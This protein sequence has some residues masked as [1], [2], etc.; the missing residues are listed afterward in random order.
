MIFYHAVSTVLVLYLIEFSIIPIHIIRF[1]LH[2]SMSYLL[3]GYG[4]VFGNRVTILVYGVTF[5]AIQNNNKFILHNL[6]IPNDFM[7]I[8]ITHRKCNVEIWNNTV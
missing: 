6:N 1:N 3:L 7:S 5:A 8:L 4:I 2:K